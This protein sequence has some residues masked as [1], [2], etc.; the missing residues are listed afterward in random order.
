MQNALIYSAGFDG[1]RQVYVYVLSH[2]L[3]EL[4]YNI[5]I[6]GNLKEKI[7]TS[8][9]VD[10]LKKDNRIVM[11][12]TSSYTQGGLEISAMQIIELQIK[13]SIEL[14][15]FAEADH[16]IPLFNAQIFSR[17]NKLRGKNI[18]IFLRPFYYYEKLSFINKLRYI[19]HPSTQWLPDVFQ[20]FAETIVKNEYTEQRIWID[21]LNEFVERNKGLFI[22]LYFGTAQ[23]RRG[24]DLLL[25]MAVEQDA[26]FVHCGLH[27]DNEKYDYDVIGLRK[28]LYDN[29]RIMETNQYISDPVTIE[30]FFKSVSHL[31]L[32][33]RSFYGSSGVMLQALT[34]G[35]PVLVPDE[36]I[37]GYR[38]KKHNL[39][40]TYNGDCNSLN[41]Q[42]KKF[43]EIPKKSFADS[44][45]QYMYNQSVIHLKEVLTNVLK[46]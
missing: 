14:T 40:L 2:F 6:A 30:Y 10:K 13:Y 35:I 17:S 28:N 1:H 29:N 25:K 38:V 19:K 32:P 11:I 18:G 12:D 7:S 5:F 3:N 44:I 21:K 26:C 37:I 43:K 20:Q 27:D 33:Y 4:K 8:L 42:F 9:Y 22:F 15:V 46:I 23:K 45:A 34:Y 31:V 24:Y 36:G 39:G 16:H 41:E